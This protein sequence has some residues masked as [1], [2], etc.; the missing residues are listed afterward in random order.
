MLLKKLSKYS[1]IGFLIIRIGLGSMFIY[2]GFPKLFG[3][4]QQWA[5]LGEAMSVFSVNFGH[6]FWGFMAAFAEFFGGFCLK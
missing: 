4:P 5:H 3:G 2:H 6:T 1:E